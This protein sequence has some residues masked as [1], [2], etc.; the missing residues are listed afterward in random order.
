MIQFS[1]T[2][3]W[4]RKLAS[5]V[6]ENVN[7]PQEFRP[8]ATGRQ[9]PASRVHRFRPSPMTAKRIASHFDSIALL[10]FKHEVPPC[11]K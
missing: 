9:W 2:Q 1:R 7:R 5:F 6:F 3:T 10:V 8:A 11:K 4:A